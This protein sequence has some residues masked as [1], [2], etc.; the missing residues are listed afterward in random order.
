MSQQPVFKKKRLFPRTP[1]GL[2]GLRA[3][4]F[5][6]MGF[7]VTELFYMGSIGLYGFGF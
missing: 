2:S 4:R 7:L 6:L 5:F 1:A 3:A